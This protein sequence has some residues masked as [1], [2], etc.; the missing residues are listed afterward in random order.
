MS[1]GE[2]LHTPPSC[3]QVVR[4]FP[5]GFLRVTPFS[6]SCPWSHRGCISP[7]RF[8]HQKQIP[9]A[10]LAHR[11]MVEA[12][13][14]TETLVNFYRVTR[15]GI[16]KEWSWASHFIVHLQLLSWVLRACLIGQEAVSFR[17]PLHTSRRICRCSP[18][19]MRKKWKLSF[20]NV[21]SVL[22]IF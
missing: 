7:G 14:A 19:N 3:D 4:S 10:W 17:K 16:P 6:P 13:R 2:C 9:R 12:L 20:R 22:K 5:I 21:T 1:P 11:A 18:I 8:P 15:R